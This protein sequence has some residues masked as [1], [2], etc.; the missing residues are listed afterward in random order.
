MSP[1]RIAE[2]E[3]AFVTSIAVARR[4]GAKLLEERATTDL[5]RLRAAPATSEREV[6]D[7]HPGRLP[8]ASV[9]AAKPAC[10]SRTAAGT[11]QPGHEACGTLRPQR[12]GYLGDKSPAQP[13]TPYT[14]ADRE[15]AQFHGPSLV[16]R[17]RGR[18]PDQPA[19]C[20]A[21]RPHSP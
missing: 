21:A 16:R 17:Q 4:Q 3:A 10:A 11:L 13:L 9:E 6:A 12:V 7:V 2:A 15:A 18:H 1:P 19:S 20:G 14:G 5:G 8:P